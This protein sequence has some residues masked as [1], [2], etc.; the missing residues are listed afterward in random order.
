MFSDPQFWV[1]VAFF[2]FLAAIFNPVRKI[3]ISSLDTQ[4]SEIKNKIDEAEN[5]KSEAQK[6]LSELKTRETKVQEE[7]KEIKLN[8]EKK[9]AELRELSSIK[10]SEQINKRKL[11]NENKIEQL[12]RET[13][14]SIKNYISNA[15]INTTTILLKNN[16]SSEIKSDLINVSIKELN[17][18]LKTK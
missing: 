1:A 2:L 15:V 7:I 6:T 9:I 4:I 13:N 17:S 8:S 3:L 5:I 16:L 11:L 12:V 14:S 18:V 10:L